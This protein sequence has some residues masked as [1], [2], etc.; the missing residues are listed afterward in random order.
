MNTNAIFI[1]HKSAI[2]HELTDFIISD[3]NKKCFKVKLTT[4]SEHIHSHLL[5]PVHFPGKEP[6]SLP[7]SLLC[8]TLTVV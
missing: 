8:T 1:L 7:K 6:F 5:S 4:P 3:E 2:F